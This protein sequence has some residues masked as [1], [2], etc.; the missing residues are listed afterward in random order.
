MLVVID[1]QEYYLFDLRRHG[2]RFQRMLQAVV[3]RIGQAWKKGESV[4]S[5]TCPYDGAVLPAVAAALR[6]AGAAYVNKEEFD[7][8]PELLDYLGPSY[9]RLSL[10]LGGI[11]EDVCVLETWKGLRRSKATVQ[12]VDPRLTLPTLDNWRG[13]QGA[14]PPGYIRALPARS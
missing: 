2:D 3:A 14:Y 11:Y 8:S 1:L 10:E 9:H 7:G 5:L 6:R 13:V 4:V 12:S